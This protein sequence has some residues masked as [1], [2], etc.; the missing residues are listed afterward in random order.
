MGLSFIRLTLSRK[1]ILMCLLSLEFV[2]LRAFMGLFILFEF[3][4][5]I[6]YSILILVIRACEAR[7][8]LSLLIRITRYKGND[9]LERISKKFLSNSLKKASDF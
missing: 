4:N 6:S 1:K 3:I 2:R 5:Q 8:G 9:N 7:F